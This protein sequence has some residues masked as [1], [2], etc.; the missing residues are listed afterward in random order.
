MWMMSTA[1]LLDRPALSLIMVW[2]TLWL[3]GWRNSRRCW[4]MAHS[5]ITRYTQTQFCVPSYFTKD[6]KRDAVISKVLFES[7]RY[8][9]HI[10]LSLT[11]QTTATVWIWLA[12]QWAI[13][14][15]FFS[16]CSSTQTS[17][18]GLSLEWN[19]FI[20][21]QYYDTL[22]F[23]L[24]LQHWFC[25]SAASEAERCQWWLMYALELALSR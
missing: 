10:P 5:N 1:F 12:F 20:G 8:L 15:F 18:R 14:Q 13:P 2:R 3:S 17:I 23:Q 21:T 4:S 6:K 22:L 25:W 19:G 11:A 9:S 16:V 7:E 24:L